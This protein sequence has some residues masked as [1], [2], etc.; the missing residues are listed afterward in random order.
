MNVEADRQTLS[1]DDQ[2]RLLE[3]L[4][5]RP[6]QFCLFLSALIRQKPMEKLLVEAI[7]TTRSVAGQGG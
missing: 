1:P 6:L 5:L 7:K 3:D 2:K 4:R